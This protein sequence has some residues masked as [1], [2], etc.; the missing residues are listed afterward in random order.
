MS[1]MDP[2][3]LGEA[4][5]MRDDDT[6]EALILAGAKC[7]VASSNFYP[8]AGAASHSHIAMMRL[9]LKHGAQING[10]DHLGT[11]LMAAAYMGRLDAVKFLLRAGADPRAR[12]AH[13]ESAAS[14]AAQAGNLDIARVL[15]DLETNVRRNRR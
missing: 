4:I 13:G 15:W 1:A 6:A 10:Q 5:M 12:N 2:T 9:L 8:L 14:I 11:A 3:P 7:N